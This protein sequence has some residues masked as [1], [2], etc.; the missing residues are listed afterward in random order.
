MD[1]T[2]C[3]T[4]FRLDEETKKEFRVNLIK[5]NLLSQ[6]LLAS[7]VKHFNKV[8]SEKSLKKHGDMEAIIEY[9]DIEINN[10]QS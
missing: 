8:C 6:N 10:G 2:E 5:S 7:F 1:N 3:M 9:A 4:C